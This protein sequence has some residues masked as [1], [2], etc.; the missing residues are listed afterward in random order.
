MDSYLQGS[1]LGVSG[2]MPTEPQPA[3]VLA[4]QPP[5]LAGDELISLPGGIVLPKKTLLLI[6]VGVAAILFIAYRKKQKG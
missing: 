2:V 1:Y 5:A 3:A 4:A 6:A